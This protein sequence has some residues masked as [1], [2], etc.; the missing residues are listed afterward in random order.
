M[1]EIKPNAD[2]T[3]SREC[4]QVE[5]VIPETPYDTWSVRCRLVENRFVF[6][7]E[8][9]PIAYQRLQEVARTRMVLRLLGERIFDRDAPSNQEWEMAED[10]ANDALDAVRELVGGDDE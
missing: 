6:G 8:I 5:H 4:P 7:S 1:S 3:C 10:Q 9:C 2:G